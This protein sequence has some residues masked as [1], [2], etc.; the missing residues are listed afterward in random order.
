MAAMEV[1]AKITV[2]G[3]VSG[4]GGVCDDG[5][6]N[7]GVRVV[8]GTGSTDPVVGRGV[9]VTD[10]SSEEAVGG[11]A[12]GGG[13][14]GRGDSCK[15][16]STPSSRNRSTSQHRF[17]ALRVRLAG[18][19]EAGGELT[20]G[21]DVG[22]GGVIGSG[23]GGIGGRAECLGMLR[24]GKPADSGTLEHETAA[25]RRGRRRRRTRTVGVMKAYRGGEREADSDTS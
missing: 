6:S 23:V 7:N 3:G 1:P 25:L 12:G 19:G 14:H 13:V 11:E 4:I 5:S 17:A 24:F 9:P 16:L 18:G 8:D 20:E 2:G 22:R 21:G 15:S 10:D